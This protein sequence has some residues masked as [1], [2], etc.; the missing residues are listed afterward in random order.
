MFKPVPMPAAEQQAFMPPIEQVM[1]I[2][3][4]SAPPPPYE[5]NPQTTLEEPL[6]TSPS[7]PFT[8]EQDTPPPKEQPPLIQEEE[9]L[10]QD[11]V[12]TN[13]AA[14]QSSLGGSLFP[15]AF[16]DIVSG[17]LALLEGL[18]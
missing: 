16:E 2:L 15:Q 10:I 4:P 17:D 3:D 14:T 18:A 5:E 8:R 13:G 6:E 9:E 11:G 7:Y 1:R 12:V